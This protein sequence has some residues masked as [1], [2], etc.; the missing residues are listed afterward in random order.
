MDAYT[1]KMVTACQA[2]QHYVP[3]DFNPHIESITFINLFQV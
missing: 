1:L 3:E 2:I